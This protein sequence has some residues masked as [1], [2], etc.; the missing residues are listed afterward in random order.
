M[1]EWEKNTNYVH[2]I[3]H[4]QLQ[5]ISTLLVKTIQKICFLSY[6]QNKKAKVKLVILNKAKNNE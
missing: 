2:K 5:M 1:R 4:T 6:R 3:V